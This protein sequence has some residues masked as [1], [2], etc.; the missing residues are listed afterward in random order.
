MC[1]AAARS[2][3]P[4][5]PTREPRR[6]SW[7]PQSRARG[8]SKP[9]GRGDLTCTLRRA[10]HVRRA[11]GQQKSGEGDSD[12][13]A[14]ARIA[15]RRRRSGRR[16]LG[17]RVVRK[18]GAVGRAVRAG[19]LRVAELDERRVAVAV[20]VAVAVGCARARS[21][22]DQPAVGSVASRTGCARRTLP[23]CRP[24]RSTAVSSNARSRASVSATSTSACMCSSS[25]R[26]T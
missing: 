12:D 11:R 14:V 3:R 17:R 4:T 7:P 26:R 23:R 5:R 13:R 21:F 15:D 20:V 9:P 25:W 24:S 16:E 8:R 19:D 6:A 1:G 22:A 18:R 10:A 2:Y